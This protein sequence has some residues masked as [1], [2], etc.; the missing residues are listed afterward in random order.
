MLC[1][2]CRISSNC[3]RIWQQ[4]HYQNVRLPV[5]KLLHDALLHC[6]LQ[7]QVSDITVK[8][9]IFYT[10]YCHCYHLLFLVIHK[11]VCYSFLCFLQAFL[12]LHA[13]LL[14]FNRVDLIKPVSNV[15]LFVQ[16][17][18]RTYVRSS[19]HKKFLWF[20]WNLACR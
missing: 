7:G 14:F 17:Y 13:F 11:K 10:S 20:Q 8:T 9:D 3:F 19:V 16:A 4:F 1:H 2:V 12:V 18:V 6:F 5:S 15:H